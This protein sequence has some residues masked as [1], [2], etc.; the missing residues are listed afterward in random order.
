MYVAINL[1]IQDKEVGFRS[2]HDHPSYLLV[3]EGSMQ[4][5]KMVEQCLSRCHEVWGLCLP[6]HHEMW[7]Y[8]L[9]QM[10]EMLMHHETWHNYLVLQV[11]MAVVESAHSLKSEKHCIAVVEL[12]YS[13]YCT[14]VRL[15]SRL[16]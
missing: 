11:Q 2:W 4:H 1:L 7:C 5:D 6:I 9:V 12:K 10:D 16:L 14:H 3:E 15:L 13:A 8:D